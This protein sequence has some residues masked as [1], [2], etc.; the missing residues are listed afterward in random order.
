MPPHFFPRTSTRLIP[1]LSFVLLY[2]NIT[3]GQTQLRLN[4]KIENSE[5]IVEGKVI[6]KESFW[7]DEHTGIFT[8][9][10][11]LVTK[12]YKGEVHQAILEFITLGGE[13]ENEMVIIPHTA[14]LNINE[15]Y[16]LFSSKNGY[17]HLSSNYKDYLRIEYEEEGIIRLPD[18]ELDE[19]KMGTEFIFNKESLSEYIQL[20]TEIEYSIISDGMFWEKECNS[21]SFTGKFEDREVYLSF[22]NSSISKNGQFIQFDIMIS[23]NQDGVE[24]GYA[25]IY[26]DYGS[27][28]FG[29][30]VVNNNMIE[31]SKGTI[32]ENEKYEL[33]IQDQSEH[34]LRIRLSLTNGGHFNQ[35]A[36]EAQIL[37]KIRLSLQNLEELANISFD[38]LAI[39]GDIYYHCLGEFYPFD[40][41]DFSTP[42]NAS[43]P[44]EGSEIEIRY[45]F[46]RV[47][48]SDVNNSI[49]FQIN[50]RS[51]FQSSLAQG[52]LYIQYN[53]KAFGNNIASNNRLRVSLANQ[54]F[55]DEFTIE[56]EDIADNIIRIRIISE[57]D[58][59][60]AN[61]PNLKSGLSKA[62]L[63]I[64]MDILDC[65]EESG[66]SFH[67]IRMQESNTYLTDA[68]PFNRV[69][70]Q[71]V[72]A[73]DEIDIRLCSCLKPVI[74]SFMPSLISAGMNKILT[75]NGSFGDWDPDNCRVI[76]PNG[77]DGGSSDAVAEIG[78]IV[79]WIDEK[80]EVIVPSV[81]NGSSIRNPA[82]SGKI[83]VAN[84]CGR[85]DKSEAELNIPYAVFN[86]RVSVER[87]AN[88]IVV[89]EQNS[90]GLMFQFSKN[91]NAY[92]DPK[93]TFAQALNEWCDK[94]SIEYSI[95][96]VISDLEVAAPNDD[97]NLI[98]REAV[99]T[100]SGR[101]A[102]LFGTMYYEGCQNT[103]TE[104]IG[105]AMKDLDFIIDPSVGNTMAEFQ[106]IKNFLLHELGHAHM[107][108]HS[109]RLGVS[110]IF[111]QDQYIVYHDMTDINSNTNNPVAKIEADDIEGANQLF[112]NSANLLN[113][114][115]C[116]DPIL[117]GVCGESSNAIN[118]SNSNNSF[119]I[120]PNPSS[121][122][123]IIELTDSNLVNPK[124]EI[125]SILG[126]L[127]YESV[128]NNT[129]T[130]IENFQ[131]GIFIV[132]IEEENKSFFKKVIIHEN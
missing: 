2:I 39:E 97:V 96:P 83:V 73:E 116:G 78:D 105:W 93:A 62:I 67:S 95:S 45:T 18:N 27:G 16:V 40:N 59:E 3:L 29:E 19:I 21:N 80:I 23:S 9:N 113:G 15:T 71:P 69:F 74:S 98:S 53:D 111:P 120:F 33:E 118:E 51:D 28:P 117:K 121:G 89:Q 94:T 100:E 122:L 91:L 75:I 52:E 5:F 54:Q 26:L 34:S 72:I 110:P 102:L 47:Q 17:T 86:R 77:D 115:S 90:S 1:L 48:I 124:L 6:S 88:K 12:V 14:N 60:K 99:T 4:D 37:F 61:L 125:Y 103:D 22:D 41:I 130:V 114:A 108:N 7:N 126:E 65:Q 24:L 20:Q 68:F 128:I 112:S 38:E 123:L 31:V 127:V 119:S 132:K 50:G 107:L 104:E 56:K 43:N 84:I 30:F 70:Y 131:N 63:N 57:L 92:P 87:P 36:Q 101:A 79:S 44:E 64:E 66:I 55:Q 32:I 129:M 25:D 81:T 11:V 76:F 8:S 106:A 49:E 10:K 13:L 42:L 109:K 35:I 85:S 82:C 58:E 46:D